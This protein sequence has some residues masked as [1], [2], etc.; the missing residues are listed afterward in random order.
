MFYKDILI[1]SHF[2]LSVK[3]MTRRKYRME[4][5]IRKVLG[6]YSGYVA[7]A[8][9]YE[10]WLDAR[11]NPDIREDVYKRQPATRT[12]TQEPALPPSTCTRTPL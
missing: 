2:C 8:A 4:E 11:E 9:L 3:L 7:E 6:H 10:R 5:L 1:L 12:L